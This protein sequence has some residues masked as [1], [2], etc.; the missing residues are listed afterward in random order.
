MKG[1]GV[2]KRE[3]GEKGRERGSENERERIVVVMKVIEVSERYFLFGCNFQ[4]T[5]RERERKG[6]DR[7]RK[8][9]RLDH[10]CCFYLYSVY[11][12]SNEK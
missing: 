11:K 9:D 10:C 8:R 3:K 4:K 1:E 2:K 6:I 7:E 12:C 5:E